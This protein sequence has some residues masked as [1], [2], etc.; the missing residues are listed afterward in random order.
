MKNNGLRSY[1]NYLLFY[2]LVDQIIGIEEYKNKRTWPCKNQSATLY[3][4]LHLEMV[5]NNV[6]RFNTIGEY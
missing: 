6:L 3:I 4:T 5:I 1:C 2:S